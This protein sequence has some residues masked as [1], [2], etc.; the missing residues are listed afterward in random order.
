MECHC[1]RAVELPHTTPL[2]AAYVEDFPAVA[3]FY[4]YPPTSEQ[5][6][7]FARQTPAD[8]GMRR[9]V[10]EVLR[11]QNRGFGADDAVE[12]ALDRFA[13]G[14]AVIVTGQQVGLFSGPAYT[15]YKAATALRTAADLAAAGTPAVAVFW[16]AAEDHDLEE[17]DHAYWPTRGE[18]Q[19]LELPPEGAT[20]RRVG[21]VALGEGVS[22]LVARA[23]ELTEGPARQQVLAAIGESYRPGETYG[24]AFG[25]LMARIFAG[26]GLILLDP[27]S[28]ELHRLVAPIYRAA[29][30][31]HSELTKGLMER[32]ATLEKAGYHAQVRVASEN[33][34]L[35]VDVDGERTPLRARDGELALGTRPLSSAEARKLFEESPALFSPNALLRPVVQDFLLNTIAYVGGPAEVAYLAQGA[36]VYQRLLGRMPVILPRASFTLVDARAARALRKYG[37]ELADMFRG[38]A[39][40]RSKMEQLLLP[41]ELASRL[42][43][44]EKALREMLVGLREPIAKLDATLV[45]ALETAENKILYQF[46]NLAGKAA[47][48]VAQRS[49]VLDAHERELVG[50]LYPNG[51]LQERLLCF[52]PMLAAQGMGLLEELVRRAVPGG[53]KHQVLYLD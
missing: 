51:E 48:A 32:S 52:L 16:L 36:V 26:T 45:G 40:V 31:Q 25:K 14:A 18:P 43:E 17:I 37:L 1:L 4:A 6:S 12:A 28:P 20:K 47:H 30:E 13:G 24:S 15:I 46:S 49:A 27:M 23:A 35:F 7:Q 39:Q 33:T 50:A 38:Q 2:Y 10:A 11:S 29:I 34:L 53:A 22:A 19:R 42:S 21:N 8:P 41:A 44:S 9:A 3:R 5:V